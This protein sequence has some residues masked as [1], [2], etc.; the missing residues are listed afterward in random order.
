MNPEV[1]DV[2]VIG[3]GVGGIAA[4]A[5]LRDLGASFAI[6]DKGTTVGGTW[7][8]NTYPGC[9]CDVPSH[10]Y[11]LSFAQNPDW[12]RSYPAQPEIESYLER[13]TDELGLRPRI[14]FGVEI[15]AIRWEDQTLLWDIEFRDGTHR[16]ARSVIM[17]TGPLSRP[18]LP[19]IEGIETF[20][21]TMFHSARWDH[22][23]DLCG[24]RVAV[25]GT[26]ASAVQFVPEIAPVVEHLTVFQR[27]A[28]WVLPRD[29]RPAPPWRQRLYRRVPFLQR[30]HRW[31]VY[32]RQELLAVAFIGRGRAAAAVSERIRT[33]VR[34][35]IDA[36]ISDPELRAAC[37]PDY[38]P[39]C[40]RLLI[41]NSWY[42]TLARPDVDLCT[43]PI[44]AITPTGVRTADGDEIEV[45]TIILGTGFSASDYPGPLRITGRAGLELADRWR[46][47]AATDLGISVDGFPNLYLLAGPSTGLGHN[48]IIF[49]IEA[50]LHH[51]RGALVHQ[52]R[53]GLRATTV[54]SDRVGAFYEEIQRRLGRTVWTTGCSSWY[55]S[56]AGQVDTLWP[57]TTVE[58]WWR[59]RRFRPDRHEVVEPDSG[60]VAAGR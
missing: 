11:S 53:H 39:G 57:G 14:H 41:A 46:T 19:A 30:L 28:P 44:R 20:A 58:Y 47:G 50:Q 5:M 25:I 6:F 3:A 16:S 17:A 43:R 10:L 24:E 7:R 27:S 37:L 2:A 22:E 38:E 45:D 31:R 29:D 13:V 8:D 1:L 40:K 54:R 26:G 49:M 32:A 21:G 55:R 18:S 52:R 42:S 51:I 60:P 35:Q 36:A 15:L 56:A 33:E 48:S 59:T 9:A 34:A 23:H 12:S 4:G